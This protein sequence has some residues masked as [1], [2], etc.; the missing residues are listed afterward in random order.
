MNI[1]SSYGITFI[2]AT[3]SPY[4]L[5]AFLAIIVRSVR[6]SINANIEVDSRM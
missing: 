4:C 6:V 3:F 5:N 1:E 2:H